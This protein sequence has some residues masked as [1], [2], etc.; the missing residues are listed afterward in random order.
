MLMYVQFE[1]LRIIQGVDKYETE[2]IHV[3]DNN[4]GRTRACLDIRLFGAKRLPVVCDSH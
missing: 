1:T 4:N 3:G 2:K